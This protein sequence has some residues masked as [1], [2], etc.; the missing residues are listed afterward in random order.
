MCP[1]K[2][3]LHFSIGSYSQCGKD[4]HNIEANI[5][6]VHEDQGLNVLT[7]IVVSMPKTSSYML[8][9]EQTATYAV[10]RKIV[11]RVLNGITIFPLRTKFP[12]KKGLCPSL[13]PFSC[14]TTL[15]QT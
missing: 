12:W 2:A 1:S 8:S 14:L 7:P 5:E 11:L 13:V 6:L 3:S 10:T 15:Q 9:I 4:H